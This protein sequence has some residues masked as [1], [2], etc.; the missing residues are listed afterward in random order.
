LAG[1][2][3]LR[4]VGVGAELAMTAIMQ[5]RRRDR[6]ERLTMAGTGEELARRLSLAGTASSGV[7]R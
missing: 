2:Q 1:S 5:S 3:R 6:L 7:E 4:S